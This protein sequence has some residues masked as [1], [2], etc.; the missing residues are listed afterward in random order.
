MRRKCVVL[1]ASLFIVVSFC[2]LL[3]LPCLE[4]SL[5]ASCQVSSV[6]GVSVTTMTVDL[7]L[8]LMTHWSS[9]WAGA[10]HSPFILPLS[11]CSNLMWPWA[12][13]VSLLFERTWTV[14]GLHL[15]PGTM[16]FETQELWSLVIFKWNVRQRHIPLVI[17]LAW[18]AIVELPRAF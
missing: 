2:Y 7:D 17:V 16:T 14:M 18:N 4:Q 6:L 1:S 12:K 15:V 8:P 11:M 10:T 9:W 13:P 5:T 3:W